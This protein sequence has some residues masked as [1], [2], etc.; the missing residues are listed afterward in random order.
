MSKVL[1]LTDCIRAYVRRSFPKSVKTL[2]ARFEVATDR[3]ETTFYCV[4]T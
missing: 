2:I 4:S 1:F 3:R